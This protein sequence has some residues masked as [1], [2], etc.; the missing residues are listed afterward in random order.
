MIVGALA[1]RLHG[2]ALSPHHYI[3]LE[4]TASASGHCRQVGCLPIMSPTWNRLPLFW[5]LS[6][7]LDNNCH[8]PSLHPPGINCLHFWSLST[9]WFSLSIMSSSW[10]KLPPI[11]VTVDRLVFPLHHVI[12]LEQTASYSGHCRQVGF[13]SPSCHLPGTNCLLFWSLLTGWFSLSIMSSSWNRLPLLLATVDRLA[14]CICL[15][16][17]K[18][19]EVGLGILLHFIAIYLLK[20]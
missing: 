2:C 13:P 5:P 12:F 7:K 9:G 10:N 6:T 18:G 15:R 17:V 19:E 1:Q 16:G 11:L 14:G 8:S 20:I 4:Q 3:P